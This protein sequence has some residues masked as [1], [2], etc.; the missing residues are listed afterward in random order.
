MLLLPQYA[1][2]RAGPGG[3]AANFL[4]IGVG[5]RAVSLGEAFSGLADDASAIHYNPAG[6]G[7]LQRYEVSFMHNE[8]FE[9]VRQEWATVAWPTKHFGTFAIA[10][11][12][13]AISPFDSYDELDQKIGTIDAKDTATTLAY[14]LEIGKGQRLSVGVAAKYIKSELHTFSATALAMDLGVLWRLGREKIYE[15]EYR[16]GVTARNL[17]PEMKFIDEGFPLPQSLNIGL[18]RNSPLPHPFEDMRLALLLEGVAPN[19]NLPY[20]A[21]GIELRIVREFAIRVGYNLKQDTG[22]GLSGG[23]GFTSLSR[24]FTAEWWPEISLDYAI[25]D[26]GKLDQAHRVSLTLKF[27]KFKRDR[28]ETRLLY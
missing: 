15:T 8:L 1:Q 27:G 23:V 12:Q 11:N 7:T 5:P 25:V 22:L 28:P 24:G 20:A 17:G 9:G 14:S 26:Y 19:D 3:S 4:K 2:A 13:L 6:L 18:C 16:I 10:Y 21:T